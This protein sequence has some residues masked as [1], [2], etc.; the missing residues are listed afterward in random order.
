MYVILYVAQSKEIAEDL[1]KYIIADNIS[2]V[3][4]G[5][6]LDITMHPNVIICNF[7]ERVGATWVPDVLRKVA[8]K[9]AVYVGLIA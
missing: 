7:V 5:D 8:H 3:A 1:R 6:T 4:Y 9:D 2:V